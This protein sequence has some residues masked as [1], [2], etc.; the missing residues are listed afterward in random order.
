MIRTGW[1]GCTCRA[2]L[3]RETAQDVASNAMNSTMNINN[4]TSGNAF[5]PMGNAGYTECLPA[6]EQR[7]IEGG[8]E[9]QGQ[10][11]VRHICVSGK[12]QGEKEIEA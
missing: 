3:S 1:K 10:T 6:N 5:L 11:E 8:E 7:S 9:K 2:A 12:W 4:G